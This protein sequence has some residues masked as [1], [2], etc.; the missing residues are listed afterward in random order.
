[1]NDLAK[2]SPRQ[3]VTSNDSQQVVTPPQTSSSSYL[4]PLGA[5]VVAGYLLAP[6]TSIVTRSCFPYLYGLVTGKLPDELSYMEYGGIYLPM[7]EHATNFA[8]QNSY[9]ISLSAG[10][11][12]YC[13]AKVSYSIT[14]TATR[15]ASNALSAIGNSLYS[16][17]TSSGDEDK[18]LE[19]KG[20]NSKYPE[21]VT[22]GLLEY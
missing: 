17:F 13:V 18:P 14:Q 20:Q 10:I 2:N 7:Q 5:S 11:A 15:V 12:I 21:V 19:I 22:E 8:Y 9:A 6:Y 1:M 3:V 16:F 4:Y